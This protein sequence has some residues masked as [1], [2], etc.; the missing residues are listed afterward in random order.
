MLERRELKPRRRPD[1]EIRFE[2]PPYTRLAHSIEPIN[3]PP[4][5][6]K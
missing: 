4:T 6:A 1:D 5:T 2:Q 3:E